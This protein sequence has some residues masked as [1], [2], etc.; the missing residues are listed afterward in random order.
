MS[1]FALPRGLPQTESQNFAS[2][3]PVNMLT[4]SGTGK[5]SGIDITQIIV[6]NPNA[7]ARTITVSRWDG[8]T[9]WPILPG[10][11]IAA[12]DVYVLEC[13]I[14]LA[15]SESIRVTPGAVDSIT[16]HVNYMV[17]ST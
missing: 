17:P 10:K 7:A 9:A 15:R 2:T 11:S 6:A 16:V 3:N 13:Y 1:I 4:A 5:D 14:R 8:T 12:N